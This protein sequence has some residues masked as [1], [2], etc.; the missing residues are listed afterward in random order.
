MWFS[1]SIGLFVHH[2]SLPPRNLTTRPALCKIRA[3]VGRPTFL[4][5][6]MHS[7]MSRS[8]LYVQA[9]D[10]ILELTRQQK[11][12]PGDQLPSESELSQAVGVSRNTIRDALM[13]LERN[14]IVV[15]RHGLGTFLAP[16]LLH[17]RTGLHQ[18]LPIPELIAA[19]GFKP[20]IRELNIASARG[21]SE[22]HQILQVPLT[23]PLQSV[24][25]LH[26]ADERPAIYITYWLIPPLSTALPNWNDFDGHILNFIE[27]HSPF[28]I[29]HTVARIS[30]VT[31]TKALADKLEVKRASPLLKMM[32]TAFTA[33]GQIVYCSTS[34]QHSDLLEVMVVRQRK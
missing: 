30:A 23:E 34:Y 16:T 15:R 11:L 3:V 2:K 1:A 7:R 21:P 33:G 20:Q 10:Q 6:K 26:L 31:A 29:H 17:L 28:C 14:G 12:K 18:M 4:P 27:R 24:S 22:A 25:L 13:L 5:A 8:Q 19:S 9:R 32:H